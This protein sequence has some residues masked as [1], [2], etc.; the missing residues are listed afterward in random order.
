MAQ[1]YIMR[2]ANLVQNLEVVGDFALLRK[3]HQLNVS[4]NSVFILFSQFNLLREMYAHWFYSKKGKTPF[5]LNSFNKYSNMGILFEALTTK[6][7]STYCN[8]SRTGALAQLQVKSCYHLFSQDIS[9]KY[10][11]CEEIGHFYFI[12]AI[13]QWLL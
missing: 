12:I 4:Q 6:K 5:T 8:I 2:R 13:N 9:V 3:T 11:K 7:I 10:T 1:L